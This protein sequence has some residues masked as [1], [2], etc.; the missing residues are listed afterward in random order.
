VTMAPVSDTA[1]GT[2]NE[3]VNQATSEAD[4][5]HTAG[6]PRLLPLV[7][8]VPEDVR[9]HLARYGRPPMGNPHLIQAVEQAGLTGRGGAAFPVHRKMAIVAQARGR[10]VIVANGAGEKFDVP[11]AGAYLEGVDVAQRQVRMNLPEGM[12]EINA[13][14]TSEEKK[15]QQS[16]R[17]K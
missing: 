4:G 2:V 17:K 5:K 8:G 16:E 7:P 12:L 3:T 13:P 11:F 14:V 9:T 1:K 10:K 6:L 15:E